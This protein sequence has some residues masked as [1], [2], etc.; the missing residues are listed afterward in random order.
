MDR[1]WA[2]LPVNGRVHGDEEGFEDGC[3]P[4]R[5]AAE[6][7]LRVRAE[8]DRIPDVMLALGEAERS[9]ADSP[10]PDESS[11]HSS[12]APPAPWEE[13]LLADLSTLRV[14]LG[15]YGARGIGTKRFP[16]IA[17]PRMKDARGWE[18]FC[19]GEARFSAA[20]RVCPDEELP[21]VPLAGWPPRTRLVL[22]F[23]AVMTQAVLAHHVDWLEMAP[24]L[25]AKHA[26]WLY[27]LLARL[28]KPMHRDTE[29]VLRRLV[30]RLVAL[31]ASLANAA[32]P[33]LPLIQ[34]LVVIAGVYFG[35][36]ARDE[37]E[38]RTHPTPVTLP[39][40]PLGDKEEPDDDNHKND[41]DDDD[42]EEEEE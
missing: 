39:A 13:S 17:L 40:P 30:L 16:R 19:F 11:G 6:Y 34:I 36:A 24:S 15:V 35:Q 3:A 32:D 38:G 4:P 27:A 1:A 14:S 23:D 41:D 25:D 2:A 12:C 28:D 37:I 18:R 9:D 22:Q 21:Q 42:E 5:S 10:T 8:A 20:A 26:L 29:S 7:L 33:R 31:R